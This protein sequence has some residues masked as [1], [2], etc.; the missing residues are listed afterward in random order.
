MND[1]WQTKKGEGQGLFGWNPKIIHFEIGGRPQIIY[2]KTV[3]CL[4]VQIH[5]TKVLLLAQYHPPKQTLQPKAR[6]C[7][8]ANREGTSPL[9][10][11]VF[12]SCIFWK[13]YAL[14]ALLSQGLEVPQVADGVMKRQYGCSGG[15]PWQYSSKEL[16]GEVGWKT[17][18]SLS[19]LTGR[20]GGNVVYIS[21]GDAKVGK[22]LGFKSWSRERVQTVGINC[23]RAT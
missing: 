5:I 21:L 14:H 16:L 19:L 2:C 17:L 23:F 13:L 7:I 18:G 11:L 12:W 20:Y 9:L 8:S 10:R 4:F 3:I 15:L 1:F 6:S 22:H